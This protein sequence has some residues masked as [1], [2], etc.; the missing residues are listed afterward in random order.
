M[1]RFKKG[2]GIPYEQQGYIY[3]ISRKYKKLPKIKREKIEAHC[4]AVGGPYW[5][6]LF[7]FVT[8]DAGQVAVCMRHYLSTSTLERLVKRYYQEF[9]KD[10]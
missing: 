2:I 3:F 8:T 1:F 4:R 10:I 7:E 5:R 6:A 9:P